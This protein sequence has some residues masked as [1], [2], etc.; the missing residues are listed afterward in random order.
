MEIKRKIYQKMLEW[1]KQ[2]VGI[3][4]LFIEG[5]RRVLNQY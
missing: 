2:D 1:K 4:A 5:A 3:S